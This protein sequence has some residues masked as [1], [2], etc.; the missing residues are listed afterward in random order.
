MREMKFS[1]VALAVAVVALLMIAVYEASVIQNLQGE[2]MELKELLSQ[3]EQQVS[4]LQEELETPSYPLAITDDLNRTIAIAEEPQRIVSLAPSN[5]EIL[6]AIGA[7]DKVVGVTE[8]CDYPE[9][10]VSRKS[11]GNLTVVG[12]FSDINV[13]V[14]IS[15]D[16]DM[17][18]AF[19]TLQVKAV[20]ALEEQG[21]PVIV[22]NPCTVEDVL[23]DIKLV[24]KA[25]GMYK[26][27][28]HLV[29]NL[30]QRI[31]VIQEKVANAPK[32]KVYYELWYD[33]LMSA[34][35]GTFI[36]DLIFMAGG[37][38]IF[39]DAKT[40]YPIVS[41]EEVIARNPDVIVLPDSYMMYYSIS[42]EQVKSRPGWDAINAVKN[43]RIYFVDEDLLVRPG[44]RLIDGLEELAKIIHPELFSGIS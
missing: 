24:G 11:S 8:Y 40:Q 28:K 17:V 21:I 29:E 30:T 15:L 22:L 39:S 3:L 20:E 44:P 16:P 7:G 12:G 18:I 34:G 23:N 35:P 27:A 33:P 25:V 6:F 32:V 42:A 9:E 26:E 10:V 13:E 37:E 5:T 38:N 14:I 41:A 1:T 4:E 2:N 31:Q 36:S 19:G 43:N